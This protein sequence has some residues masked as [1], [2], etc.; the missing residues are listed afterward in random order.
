[1][2]RQDGI[3]VRE[4]THVRR[5]FFNPDD[6]SLVCAR[7]NAQLF[8]GKLKEKEVSRGARCRYCMDEA[9]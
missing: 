1:M 7:H 9:K 3:G 8:D 5:L 2:T 4:Q 6:G